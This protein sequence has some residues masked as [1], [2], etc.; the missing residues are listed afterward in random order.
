MS[1]NIVVITGS[2]RK[3]GNSFAMTDAFIETVKKNGHT[4]TRFDAAEMNVAGCRAC[5]TCFKT[6]KACSAG[7]DFNDV[8]PAIENADVVVLTMPLYWY[9]YPAQIKAVIDKFY[10]F[11]VG[12]RDVAGKD[13]AVLACCEEDD[14]SVME[15]ITFPCKHMTAL[16]KWNYIG[17]VYVTN[18]NKAGD[19]AQTDGISRVKEF[20]EKI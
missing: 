15:G 1:K 18:V 4:V 2:P 14:V 13:C 6:G 16:V 19:I 17:E 7:D 9:T 8:A 20:A 3:N 10:S 5:N 11:F 12:K